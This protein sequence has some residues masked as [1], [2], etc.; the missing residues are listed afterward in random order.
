[1]NWFFNWSN[2]ESIR[3]PQQN[4]RIY[5]TMW[6]IMNP[7]K[8]KMKLRKKKPND[9]IET[10]LRWLNFT[11]IKFHA[12]R[13][14]PWYYIQRKVLT[15]VRKIISPRTKIK[16]SDSKN[17]Q[18]FWKSCKLDLLFVSFVSELV[19]CFWQDRKTSSE[20]SA[21]AIYKNNTCKVQ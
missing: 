16:Y 5:K 15:I 4:N 2:P 6:W 19:H 12:I 17:I 7:S 11:G 18:T 8:I 10:T 1:M 20:V 13:Y 3:K 9:K 21:K 14:N